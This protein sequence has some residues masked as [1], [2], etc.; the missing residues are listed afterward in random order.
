MNILHK[1]LLTWTFQR[2]LEGF[3]IDNFA[4]ETY[5]DMKGTMA[6]THRLNTFKVCLK[7]TSSEKHI[8]KIYII[9]IYGITF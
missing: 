6:Q 9:K 7:S 8:E 1:A 4:Q 3:K 2:G 5:E